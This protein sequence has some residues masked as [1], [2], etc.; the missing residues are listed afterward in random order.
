MIL[1]SEVYQKVAD[2]LLKEANAEMSYALFNRYSKLA[3]LDFIDWLS[4]DV[5]GVNPPEPYTTQKNRDYLS[6]FIEPYPKQVEDGRIPFP[7]DY[8][9]FDNMVLLGNYSIPNS[10]CDESNE[11]KPYDVLRDSNTPIEIL[12]GNQFTVRCN[13]YIKGLQPSF[14]KPIAKE[15]GKYFEFMPKD[16]GS[17]KLWYIRYPKFA[18][19]VTKIDTQFMEE[20]VDEDLT[21]N[22]EW[23]AKAIP[24]LIWFIVNRF[25]DRTSNKA[26]KEFNIATGKTPK[27]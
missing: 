20:V 25:A 15:V 13:T 23:D 9:L 1:A 22:Y 6:P 26:Q 24:A 18:D 8:Y 10:E 19:I 4:G 7:S 3:E 5:R 21:T 2:N 16:L 27:G 17:I 11:D 12:D 14:T